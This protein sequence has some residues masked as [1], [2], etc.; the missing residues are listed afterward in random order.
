MSQREVMLASPRDYRAMGSLGNAA[1]MLMNQHGFP[2]LYDPD[3]GD[4]VESADHDRLLSWHGHDHWTRC[5][6]RHGGD[7][8]F[9]FE[10]WL[11]NARPE[12]LMGFIRDLLKLDLRREWTGFRILYT[13]NR[14]NGYPVYSLQAFSK[15]E[16]ST[17]EVYSGHHAPNVQGF[18][19][20]MDHCPYDS[21]YGRASFG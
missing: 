8:R 7:A 3:A 17:T 14:S 20:D 10:N 2:H 11:Q 5:L 18:E 21:P 19:E 13:V 12:A 4:R 9:G 15:G 1:Y 16:N 6:E